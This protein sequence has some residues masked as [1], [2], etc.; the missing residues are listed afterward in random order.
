[1]NRPLQ[2]IMRKQHTKLNVSVRMRALLMEAAKGDDD[3]SAHK[4]IALLIQKWMKNSANSIN[5][6]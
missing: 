4:K 1:M 3:K 5:S 2:N 6:Q